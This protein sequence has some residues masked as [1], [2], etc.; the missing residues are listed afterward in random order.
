MKST[1]ASLILLAAANSALAADPE[2]RP[3]ATDLLKR[4]KPGFGGL[5][6]VLVDHSTGDLWVMLSD[7]GV[8]HSADHGTSWTQ[9][10]A[11]E[12]KGRTE[13]PGCWLLDPTGKSKTM[14]S[15][16]V[17]GAPIA[18]SPDRATT[19]SHLD[20]KSNHIDWCAVDW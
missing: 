8:F 15:A 1:I 3:V 4:E 11:A 18:V 20:A 10:G 17:Y 6:G 19:W 9:A 2:W 7:R 16:L 14:V 5:C 13:A 12:Q